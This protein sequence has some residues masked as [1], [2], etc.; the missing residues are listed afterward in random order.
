MT[1]DVFCAF[2][3]TCLMDMEATTTPADDRATAEIESL[4]RAE[5]RQGD[6]QAFD[7]GERVRAAVER[8]AAERTGATHLTP[9]AIDA[10]CSTAAAVALGLKPPP[11]SPG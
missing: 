10:P 7:A 3:H 8:H 9:A 5:L 1:G 6:V 2:G 4:R 11:G